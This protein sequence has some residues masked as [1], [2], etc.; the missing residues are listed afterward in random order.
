[1]T[2]SINTDV[3]GAELQNENRIVKRLWQM[4]GAS[5]FLGFVIQR[6]LAAGSG[7]ISKPDRRH[8]AVYLNDHLAG[9]MAGIELLMTLERTH[10]EIE[11]ALA[12]LRVDIEQDQTELKAL[13][14]R[15]NIAES[16][17]RKIGG[18]LLEKTTQLKMR[19]DD[20][21]GGVLHL[22]ESLEALSLGIEGKLAL[23]RTLKAVADLSPDLACSDY[24]RLMNRAIEQRSR[25]EALSAAI[26]NNCAQ[27][28]MISNSTERFEVFDHRNKGWL[29]RQAWAAAHEVAKRRRKA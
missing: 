9:S 17:V 7:R 12:A 1:M 8:L 22:F 18:W 16:G 3:V 5:L 28:N 4:L 2:N 15:L 29:L 27:T 24:Q 26:R 20:R 11:P 25:A 19:I 13:M 21:P 14:V 6:L 23:W 10:V